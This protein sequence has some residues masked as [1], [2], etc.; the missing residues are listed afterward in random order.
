MTNSTALGT[1]SDATTTLALD[2]EARD[3]LADNAATAYALDVLVG[4][5]PTVWFLSNMVPG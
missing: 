4:L 5:V 2:A 3:R 1:A